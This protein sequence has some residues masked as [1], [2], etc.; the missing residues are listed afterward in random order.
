[1]GWC[2]DGINLAHDRGNLRTPSN[3]VYTFR[4]HKMQGISLLIKELLDF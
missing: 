4:L 1:M 3:A 2:V